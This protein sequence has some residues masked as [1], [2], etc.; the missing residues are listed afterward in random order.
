MLVSGKRVNQELS[1]CAVSMSRYVPIGLLYE[2]G[3]SE[4]SDSA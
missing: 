3:M 2:N 1:S 4:N